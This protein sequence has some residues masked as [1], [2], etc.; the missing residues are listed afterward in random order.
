[1]VD[2]AEE[3]VQKPKQRKAV[4]AARRAL[5]EETFKRANGKKPTGPQDFDYV[6]ELLA[7][8]VIG[9]P[10][11]PTYVRA[12]LENL[13][14]KYKNKKVGLFKNRG[15]KS[16]LKKALAN[17]K[18]DEA[19]RHGLD[20]LKANPWDVPTLTRMATAASESGDNDSE[21][22][23]LKAALTKAPK[24][25]TCN[26]L[27]AIALDEMGLVNQAIVFWERVAEALP[28]DKEA[29]WAISEFQ[30][31]AKARGDAR[32]RRA[33]VQEREEPAEQPAPEPLHVAAGPQPEH[34][35]LA[36][37]LEE[38]MLAGV[39]ETAESPSEEDDDSRIETPEAAR[40]WSRFDVLLIGGIIVL[41]LIVWFSLPRLHLWGWCLWL[42]DMRGW[43]WWT[44][45]GVGAALIGTFLVTYLWP[46]RDQQ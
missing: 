39:C 16:A 28:K 15:A 6:A 10:S 40:R 33:T 27:A 46:E 11:N 7:Q 37:D 21:L 29:R 13:Q 23:Y 35:G 24:D 22:C 20:V 36:D 18:W 26:R 34:I 3:R 38:S 19:I 9:D 14:K 43:R 31:G 44:W 8:C 5:L 4:S 1:M 25:P 42:L 41:L 45:T 17:G 32:Q 30:I 2:I 12:Y